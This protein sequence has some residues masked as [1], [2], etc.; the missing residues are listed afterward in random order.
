LK[1]PDEAER[2]F[3]LGCLRDLLGRH[4]GRFVTAEDG[5]GVRNVVRHKA[6]TTVIDPD[7]KKQLEALGYMIK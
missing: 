1:P 7:T 3:A 6:E 4:E 2:R 5:S